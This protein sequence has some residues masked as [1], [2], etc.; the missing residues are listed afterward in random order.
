MVYETF[1]VV[2]KTMALRKESEI[3]SSALLVV[4]VDSARDLP[5]SM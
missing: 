3:E 1:G 4:H 2:L 5:V